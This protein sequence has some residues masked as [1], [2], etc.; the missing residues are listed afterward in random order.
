[1]IKKYSVLKDKDID[2]M[3]YVLK[4]GV[5]TA[6]QIQLKFQEP[7]LD[8]VYRRLRKLIERGYIKHERLAHKVGVYIGTIEAR[9]LTESAVTLPSKLSL[10]T[11]QHDLLLTDLALYYEFYFNKMGSEFDYISERESRYSIIEGHEKKIGFK[12]LTENKEAIPDSIF[13]ITSNGH[14]QKIWVE[15]E[16]NKKDQK[17]YDEKFSQIIDPA[18]QTGEYSAVW[19]FKKRKAI[20]NAIDQAKGKILTGDKI[21]T[22]DIPQD[23]LNDDWGKVVPQN[24]STGKPG[25]NE[26]ERG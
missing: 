4:N 14:T 13:L 15:L 5:V 23:I 18:L 2:Y 25:T 10:Y 9:D 3:K 8:R 22:F 16:L 7:N 6:K 20:E 12:R 19:Y 21:K 26:G 24:G 11:I 1:M 17:R